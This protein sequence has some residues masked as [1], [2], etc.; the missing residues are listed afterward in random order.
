[1][2]SFILKLFK[3]KWK[4]KKPP[5]KKVLI[6]DKES[7]SL[8]SFFFNKDD[9]HILNLRYEEI[10]FYVLMIT[11][12]LT[13][14]SKIKDNYKHNYCKI[15]DPFIIFSAFHSNY[16]FF[17]L[18]NIYSKAKYICIHEQN[19]D[20]RFFRSCDRYYKN[21]REKLR[22]DLMFVLGQYYKKKF[23]NYISAKIIS[24][25]GFKNN[26]FM[27]DKKKNEDDNSIL[28][29]SQIAAK[30]ENQIIPKY[31]MKIDNEKKIVNALLA[32]CNKKNYK[33]KIS[34]K[35]TA[36]KLDFYKRKFGEGNYTIHF[37]KKKHHSPNEPA[38]Y[39]LVNRSTF[40]VFTN[41][42][43][44]LEA[45]IKGIKGVAFPPEQFPI[46]DH[47]KKFSKT[48]PFWSE[49]FDEKILEKYLDQIKEY[50]DEEWKKIVNENIGDLIEYDPMNSKLAKTM[51]DLNIK[52][53]IN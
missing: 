34:T 11:F 29:I 27:K 22:A 35:S 10:N 30:P 21:N 8:A 49:N 9:C 38:S 53:L 12:F 42:T 18:K 40:V 24:I 33:L 3:I 37:R 15:V 43:L 14:F 23:S 20:L 17:R 13:G 32:Y 7:I 51:N 31:K 16:S 4:F 5:K 25:G 2:S 50:S 28:F 36:D 26:F 1:M 41:S 52:T 46:A 48:G 6:Y 44:G 19:T 47:E 39:D 45:L